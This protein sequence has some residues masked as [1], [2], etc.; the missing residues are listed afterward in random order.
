LQ[1]TV[2][3]AV[4]KLNMDCEIVKVDNMDDILE[5]DIMATPGLVID[6]QVVFV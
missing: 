3:D 6:E 1:K 5:Y 4:K 2:E